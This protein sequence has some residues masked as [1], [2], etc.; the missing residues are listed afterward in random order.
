MSWGS[1]IQGGESF[2]QVDK[3]GLAL[4]NHIGCPIHYPAYNKR[5]FECKCSIVFPVWQV[6]AAMKS[7]DWSVIDM[8][9][10]AL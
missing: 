7:K 1:Y 4:S 3:A 8:L 9:H 10:S 6:E 2:E 5:L